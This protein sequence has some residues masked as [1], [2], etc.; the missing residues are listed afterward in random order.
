V[1]VSASC[2][3][4][5][6]EPIERELATPSGRTTLSKVDIAT[7]KVLAGNVTI[8]GSMIAGRPR[9]L[10]EKSGENGVLS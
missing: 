4:C 6:A 5:N 9:I 2:N 8:F 7:N 3:D 1:A 10:A